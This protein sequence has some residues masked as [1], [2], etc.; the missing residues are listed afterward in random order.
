MAVEL[1]KP[2]NRSERKRFLNLV[3]SIHTHNPYYRDL[4]AHLAHSFLSG[5]DSF[6]RECTISCRFW[7]VQGS[8]RAAC[9]FVIHPDFPALQVAFL[10][11]HRDSTHLLATIVAEARREAR[12][13]GLPRVVLGLQGH[14]SYG[15]GF[16]VA[17][18]HIPISF[19]SWYSPPWIAQA[20]EIIPE[21]HGHNLDAWRI[22]L[23]EAHRQAPFLARAT[24]RKSET[25][26]IHI[27]PMDKRHFR[28]DALLLGE[29]SNRCLAQT[30]WYFPKKPQAMMEL[31]SEIRVFLRG[32]NLLFAYRHGEAVGFLFW[33]PDYNEVLPGGRRTRLW[34]IAMRV[35]WGRNAIQNCKLNAIGIVPEQR[36]TLVLPALL[37]AFLHY[38]HPRFRFAETNFVWRDNV[39]SQLLNVNKMRE[40]FR[41]YRVYECPA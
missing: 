20:L 1:G 29:L 3:Y 41:D 10:E 17:P 14:V 34:E 22:D 19:D 23:R 16:L 36:T 30:P 9:L 33:H 13:G 35:I 15:I 4:Q 38:A 37:N 2:I 40:H 5:G 11:C 7:Q 12:N 39:Q 28:R 18:H 27:R 24:L 26:E 6:I 8:D 31:L 21:L 25:D 32:E